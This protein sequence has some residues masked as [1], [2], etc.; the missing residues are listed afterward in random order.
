MRLTGI[1]IRWLLLLS[2][3][4][5]QNASRNTGKPYSHADASLLRMA[6]SSIALRDLNSAIPA[7]VVFK[8]R[9]AS[10]ITANREEH[11]STLMLDM[12][13]MEYR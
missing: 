6:S 13:L 4:I 11:V 3:D 8:D 1:E 12:P 2:L 10:E 5:L 7:Q 9:F